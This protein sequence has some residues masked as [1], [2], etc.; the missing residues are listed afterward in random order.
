MP[1][2]RGTH[3]VP[4]FVRVPPIVVEDTFTA[5]D[6]TA[7]TSLSP[8]WT[9]QATISSNTAAPSVDSN[10]VHGENAATVSFYYRDDWASS[11]ADYAVEAD[12]VMRSDTNAS[13]I[14]VVARASTS[15]NTYYVFRYLT[16]GNLWRLDRILAGALAQIGGSV[17]Q[18]LTV[19][20]AYRGRLVV[21]GQFIGGYVDGALIVSGMDSAIP[22]AGRAGIRMS[23]AATSTTGMHLDSWRVFQ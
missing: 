12:F 6:G 2:R 21:A 10:R 16:S 5:A 18:T 20:Q 4:A 13:E 8:V 23:A 15:A 14:G 9:K 19:D 22:A 1:I 3:S 7:I 11:L 17:G